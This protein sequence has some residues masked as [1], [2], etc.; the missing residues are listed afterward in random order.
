MR[1]TACNQTIE[2]QQCR[3]SHVARLPPNIEW[4]VF[5]LDHVSGE[6]KPDVRSG[7]KIFKKSDVWT[8][9]IC[10]LIVKK[11][12]TKKYITKMGQ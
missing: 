1:I 4:N 3:P 2:R 5:V 8:D 11:N 7:I 12:R 6:R 9:C 10:L